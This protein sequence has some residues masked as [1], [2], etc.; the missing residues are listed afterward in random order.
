[1]IGIPVSVSTMPF[2]LLCYIVSRC[3]FEIQD[4]CCIGK[5]TN[6]VNWLTKSKNSFQVFNQILVYLLKT[7]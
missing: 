5:V 2:L 1:M 4:H 3:Q 6:Q 7:L